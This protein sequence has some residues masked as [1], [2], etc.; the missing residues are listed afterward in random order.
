MEGRKDGRKEGR[1]DGRKEGASDTTAVGHSPGLAA[2]GIGSL[3]ANDNIFQK[4]NIAAKKVP[5]HAPTFSLFLSQT[6]D[7]RRGSYKTTMEPRTDYF[8]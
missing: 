3:S 2:A 6:H 1:K 7:T 5:S 8:D 4:E